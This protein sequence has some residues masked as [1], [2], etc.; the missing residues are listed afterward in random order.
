MSEEQKD[1]KN[2]KLYDKVAV[3]PKDVKASNS[4]NFLEKIRISKQKLWYII[5]EKQ[6]NELQTIKYNNKVGVNLKI[7]T[8]ELKKYYKNNPLMKEHIEHLIVEGSDK[9]SMIKNIPNVEINGKKLIT[10]LME[11]LIKL[12][13]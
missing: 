9:F 3:M 5:I 11:D 12:L 8:E 13:K 1:N 2:V 6:E 4:I 10:I 7:F